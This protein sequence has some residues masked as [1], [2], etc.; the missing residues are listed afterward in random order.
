L[1]L[2]AILAAG[3]QT[4]YPLLVPPIV[5]AGAIVLGVFAVR[6]LRRGAVTRAELLRAAGAVAG[7][8][9]LAAAFTPVAFARNV[10]YWRSILNGTFSFVGLPQYDLPIG[11]LP[12]WLA[13]TREFYDLPHLAE[14]TARQTLNSIFIPLALAG[15]IGYGIWRY[16]ATAIA[17]PVAV[18]A[19]LLAYYTIK[20][21]QCSYC[22]QRNLLVIAPITVAGIGVGLAALLASRIRV[23]QILAFA[24]AV[25]T[26]VAVGGEA[27]ESNRRETDASYIFDRQTRQALAALPKTL[28]AKL[29]LEGFGQGP[30]AQMEDPMVYS[31]AYEKLGG[32]PS[33]A[34]ETDD[35]YGLQYLGGPRP[36]GVEFN[37]YYRYVLTRLGGIS[38]A[39]R[40][41]ARYGPIALQ[42]RARPLDAVI[43]GGVDVA[44][45]HNEPLGTAWVNSFPVTVWVT[46][47]APAERVWTQLTFQ[48]TAPGSV[49]VGTG[50]GSS[51]ASRRSGSQLVV[52]L[53]MPSSGGVLRRA[54][55]PLAFNAIPQPPAPEDFGIPDP[56]RGLRLASVY[57]LDHPC[58]LRA[59]GN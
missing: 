25:V 13:Q 38:T 50:S 9:I 34:G 41:I 48:I 18:M 56:P 29:Q 24:I 52:C 30:K 2:F 23:L 59:T 5:L 57:A 8:L 47:A 28:P 4:A 16:R 33:I 36:E 39:R 3:L 55:V 1:I 37:P 17:I 54:A 32:P 35:N 53:G 6:R 42:E 49:S 19:G 43:T 45:A 58:D 20:H 51:T 22:V 31:A 11:V 26:L 27:L 21:N 44:L 7:V 12:G 10:R 14:L 40:T 46:G 15:V